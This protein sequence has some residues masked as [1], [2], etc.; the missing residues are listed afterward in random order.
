MHFCLCSAGI[1]RC[2]SACETFLVH[3]SFLGESVINQAKLAQLKYIFCQRFMQNIIANKA[4]FAQARKNEKKKKTY[5]GQDSKREENSF[6]CEALTE[7]YMFFMFF[8]CT[9]FVNLK[10]INSWIRVFIV[11]AQL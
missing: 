4:I 6:I 11:V 9:D 2:T 10:I 7:L 5:L 8:I 1:R 3:E